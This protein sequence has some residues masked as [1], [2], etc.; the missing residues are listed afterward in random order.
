MYVHNVEYEVLHATIRG[1]RGNTE[2]RRVWNRANA[3]RRARL[4]CKA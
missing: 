3:N 2:T 1:R 4:M